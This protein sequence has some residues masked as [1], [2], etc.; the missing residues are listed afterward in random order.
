MVHY[1]CGRTCGWQVKLCDPSLTRAIPERFRDEQLITKRYTNK[2]SFSGADLSPRLG[3]I[4]WDLGDGSPPAGSRGR[5]MI[6]RLRD[7]P[8]S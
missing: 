2:A 4:A 5:A 6:W 1:T 7:A 3:D 8:R